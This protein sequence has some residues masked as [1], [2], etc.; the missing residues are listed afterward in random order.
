MQGLHMQR[1]KKLTINIVLY[2]LLGFAYYVFI[3]L[4]GLRLPC[5]TYELFHFLCPGCGIT[6]MCIALIEGDIILAFRQNAFVL[7]LLPFLAVWGIY[8]AYKYVCNKEPGLFLWEK[9]VFI[10]VFLIAVTFSILRNLE[11]FV[12][13]APIPW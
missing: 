5:V 4:T 7:C 13:L 6:R 9:I 3:K 1:L 10:I 2:T 8:K 12:F 11:A